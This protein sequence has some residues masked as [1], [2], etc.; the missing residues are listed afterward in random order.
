MHSL[1]LAI[2]SHEPLG[3]ALESLFALRDSRNKSREE[4]KKKRKKRPTKSEVFKKP[5]NQIN[6]TT[7]I[8]GKSVN[9]EAIVKGLLSNLCN[10]R[11]EN[12]SVLIAKLCGFTD[13]TI[14]IQSPP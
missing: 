12:R 3:S 4:T 9:T 11:G 5:I 14:L 13:Q 10:A 1:K 8:R 6:V 7:R 2:D